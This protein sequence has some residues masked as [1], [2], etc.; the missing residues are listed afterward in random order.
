MNPEKAVNT[1][2]LVAAALAAISVS[3]CSHQATQ[4][5]VA[6]ECRNSALTDFDGLVIIAPHPDD[7]VLGFAG[8]AS[9]FVNAGKPVRTIVV[10]DG[11]GYCGACALWSTGSIN[12]KACE[13]SLLSNL[14]TPEIDSLAEVRRA[15]SI[16]AARILGRPAPEFLT[17][18]DTGIGIARA[19]S[20]AGNPDQLLRRSDFSGCASC[21]ECTTGWGTGPETELSASTLTASLDRIIGSATSDTLIAT[22]HWLDSHSDHAA[23]GAFVSERVAAQDSGRTVAYAVIHANSTKSYPNSECWYP[24]PAAAECSCFDEARIDGDPGWLTAL[25]VHRERP[26]WPQVL[27]DDVDYG[28]PWQLCLDEETRLAKPL[29]IDAFETQLGTVGRTPGL[30][31]ESRKGLLDC[32]GYLRSFGRRTEVFVVKEISD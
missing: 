30:L 12:G 29:A 16:A 24:G 32:S 15:E 19:N 9:V 14:E 8:L 28:E 23:L 13:A 27:P 20:E 26:D 4:A 18:P 25:R 10:T 31:P 17:Y 3:A 6:G 11:D 22:T 2:K 1:A 5:P 21:G 7:E